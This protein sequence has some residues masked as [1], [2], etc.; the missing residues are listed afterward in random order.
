M[1]NEKFS[2]VCSIF[3]FITPQMAMM[4]KVVYIPSS[5]TKRTRR[6]Q[7]YETAVVT[8]FRDLNCTF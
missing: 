6:K 3:V 4:R 1:I 8:L 5:P 2:I 7:K